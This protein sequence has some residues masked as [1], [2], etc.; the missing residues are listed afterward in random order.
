MDIILLEPEHEGNVG[1]VCRAM[2]NF[3]FQNLT[4]INPKCDL[5]SD[6]VYRRA[7]HSKKIVKSIKVLKKLPKYHTLIGTTSKLSNDYNVLR[8]PITP[9]QLAK[10]LPRLKNKKVG[11]MFGREGIGLTN[12]EI[13]KCDLLMSINSAKKYSSLNL[14]HAVAIVLYELHKSSKDKLL[15]N[16]ESAGKSEIDQINKMNKKIITKTFKSK[17]RAVIQKQIWK[18]IFRR[19]TMSKREAFG[20]MGL[21]NRILKKI[22]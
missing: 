9:E 11:I 17:E 22:K 13:K 21:L 7:K 3:N 16:I 2:A 12:E 20:V 15:D 6:D 1:A 19:S 5:K 4:I 8:T 14:S 10:K 18:N